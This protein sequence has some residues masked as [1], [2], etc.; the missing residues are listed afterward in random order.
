M[1]GVM[2]EMGDKSQGLNVFRE[3]VTRSRPSRGAETSRPTWPRH[4]DECPR[5]ISCSSSGSLNTSRG[6]GTSRA[7]VVDDANRSD[8]EVSPLS[9]QP[10]FIWPRRTDVRSEVKIWNGNVPYAFVNL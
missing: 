5:Q 6:N 8:L 9:E 1:V 4:P 7:V 3:P 2:V 10:F